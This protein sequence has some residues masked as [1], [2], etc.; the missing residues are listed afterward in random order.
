[1]F[2]LYFMEICAENIQSHCTDEGAG[3][4]IFKYAPADGKI[5]TVNCARQ[6]TKKYSN[7]K[8]L[9]TSPMFIT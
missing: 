3:K 4:K 7:V 1:M 8:I 6:A 9:M 2:I 5:A